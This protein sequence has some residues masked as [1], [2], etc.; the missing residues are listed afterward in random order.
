[1]GQPL[2]WFFSSLGFILLAGVFVAAYTISGWALKPVVAVMNATT[3]VMRGIPPVKEVTQWLPKDFCKLRSD[4]YML[5]AKQRQSMNSAETHASQTA[6]RLLNAE[7][8]L[9]EAFTA[10]QGIFAASDEGVAWWIPMAPSLP[11]MPSWT[12][13]SA[14]LWRRSAAGM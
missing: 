5:F 3:S 10:L 11:P 9:R 1:M 8:L 6:Q 2:D 12:P 13:P 4:I 7:R 14:S